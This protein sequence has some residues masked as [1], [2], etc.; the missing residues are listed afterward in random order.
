[1]ELMNLFRSDRCN[2]S[3]ANLK[4]VAM[5]AIVLAWLAGNVIAQS[6]VTAERTFSPGERWSDTSGQ[7]INAHGGGILFHQGTYYWYG[8]LKEGT[9]YL[10]AANKSWGG[11]RVV[12][13][14]FSC[15]SSTNLYDW[16]NEGIALT[17]SQREPESD[18]HCE[19]VNE[20]PK[21]IY[22]AK[23]KQFVMWFHQ[24]EPDYSAARS[25]V[26]VSDTA[27]GPFKY[28][29]SFRP[30][31]GIW[32]VNATPQDKR[33]GKENKLAHD[34]AGGQMARDMTLFVDDDGKAYQFYSSEGNPTMHVSLLTDDY[35]KP[36]GKYA[37]IFIGRSMEAPAVFKRGGK[38]YLIASG[39]TA[40]EPNAARSAVADNIFGPWTELGNPCRGIE[41]DKT[42]RGQSTFVLPVAGRP[43]S[44]IAMF[45]RWKQW[46]LRDSRYIWLPIQFE[47]GAPIVEWQERWSLNRR[48]ES[49]AALMPK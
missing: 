26:A 31:A 47:H 20:R 32:P 13:G 25:G 35:L 2:R 9:T 43:D 49:T 19:K 16:K 11:T 36:A 30:N 39:C 37:R 23:T 7:F 4:A 29:G 1:M 21:V 17:P 3:A 10:T 45:D 42:F 8:E 14:G 28:I 27:T 41:A 40:W 24:D 12:N 15:Y 46:D 6:N 22:N 44:Y 18:L 38:Y 5:S 33:P 48:Q 34:F